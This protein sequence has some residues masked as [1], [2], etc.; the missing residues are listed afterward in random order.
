M[1]QFLEQIYDEGS[2]V[3]SIDRLAEWVKEPLSSDRRKDSTLLIH[4]F[5]GISDRDFAQK[6][7]DSLSHAFPE[8]EIAG[9]VSNGEIIDG[10]ISQQC[11]LMSAILFEQS[12]ISVVAF[13]GDSFS[14]RSVGET[15]LSI[16]LETPDLKALELLMNGKMLGF[17][18]VYGCLNKCDVDLP[19][20]GGY[21]MGH[22]IDKD[23]TFLLT[24]YGVIDDGL[25]A[26]LYSGKDLH[27]DAGRTTG[28]K[29]LG[30]PFT[31]TGAEGRK[32]I[33]MNG[34]PAYQLYDS[35]LKFPNDE[36]LSRYALE[37]PL[38]IQKGK[39]EL[40]RHPQERLEDDSI[41][42]DGSV[43]EKMS[44]YLSYG[45]P[46]TIIE[47]INRRCNHI[48][49]F[50]PEAILLY[51]CYGRKNYW[52]NFIDWEME[53]FQKLACT[54]GGCIG[55]QIMRNHQ[56][57]RVIEHRLTL[58]SVAMREGE[59]KNIPLPSCQ[60]DEAILKGRTSLIN[61]MSTLVENTVLELQKSIDSLQEM[62]EKLE[63]A[64]REL[65]RVAVTDALT[66]LYNRREIE[67]LIHSALLALND[68]GK[69]LSLIMLDIDYFKKVNDTYGHDVGDIVIKDVAAIIKSFVNDSSGQAAGRW[70]GE[71]FFLLLPGKGIKE[72]ASI[73]EELRKTVE[74]HEFG[75]AGHKTV[76]LGVVSVNAA[77]DYLGIFTRAD[78]A[79]YE[80]KEGGRN[81]VVIA[82]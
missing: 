1:K 29:K 43:S 62:N 75:T 33:S 4:L 81:R 19:F 40:L 32:L 26:V 67:R 54:G 57:G 17:A 8:A 73:A 38:I 31:V 46:S 77:S 25:V 14:A 59:K 58:L 55:G 11:I 49:D 82:K 37:F 47:R 66:G 23:P 79:L 45:D 30:R 18:E 71:E 20:F 51:S 13:T 34:I 24:K 10:T 7:V 21:A 28:W 53:P 3:C 74:A 39:M 42:L 12:T 15:L 63:E 76:S 64:N 9:I 52:G 50:E 48:R 6:V 56:T 27:V 2:L 44:I 60:V 78:Q 36:V 5:C 41:M 61:R 72:A 68:P 22:D 69:E 65:H 80:A 35:F 16:A 70:G